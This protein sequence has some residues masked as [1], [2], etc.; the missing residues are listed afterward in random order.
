M[1]IDR[2]GSYRGDWPDRRH[3]SFNADSAFME[4]T[5]PSSITLYTNSRNSEMLNSLRTLSICAVGW[6]ARPPPLAAT[7]SPS[8]AIGIPSVI[9]ASTAKGSPSAAPPT[10][11]SSSA[12][13]V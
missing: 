11:G 1:I 7:R 10:A 2:R 4:E 5:S 8:A 12:T 13:S 9:I 3:P 6:W